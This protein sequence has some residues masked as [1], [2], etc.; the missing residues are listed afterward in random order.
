MFLPSAPTRRKT[1]RSVDEDA[2]TF[3]E[4]MMKVTIDRESE[5]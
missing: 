3:R 5:R 4:I 2:L 1:K